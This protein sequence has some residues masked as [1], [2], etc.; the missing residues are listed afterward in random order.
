MKLAGLTPVAAICE[1]LND[2]GTMA[3]LPQ[4]ME[5]AKKHKLRIISVA[6]LIRYRRE[7]EKHLWRE[8]ESKL[9]T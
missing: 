4:L 7:N 1:I 6:D 8:A 3:R 2:D 9:P 5:F